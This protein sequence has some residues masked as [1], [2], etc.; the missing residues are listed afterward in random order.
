[1]V[2][3]I[4][5][6]NGNYCPACNLTKLQLNDRGIP[7]DTQPVTDDVVQ[8]ASAVMGY[9]PAQS[10]VVHAVTDEGHRWWDGYR[11]DRIDS[12]KGLT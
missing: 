4:V 5:H 8:Q 3:V 2:E 1:M 12:L 11:P 9:A 10:P 7:F 6:T